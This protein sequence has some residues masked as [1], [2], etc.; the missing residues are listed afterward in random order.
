MSVKYTTIEM[1]KN[2]FTRKF[3]GV[4]NTSCLPY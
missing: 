2:N 4:V 1:F 3:F